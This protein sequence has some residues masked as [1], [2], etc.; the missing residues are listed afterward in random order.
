[1]THVITAPVALSLSLSANVGPGASVTLTQPLSAG[2]NEIRKA[3]W[4][5]LA[6]PAVTASR[7]IISEGKLAL[8]PNGVSPTVSPSI[9]NSLEL[10][11]I[12]VTTPANTNTVGAVSST[13]PPHGTL[14]I[15]D[16]K[17]IVHTGSVGNTAGT[18]NTY[19]G[20]TGL[21]Q[22]GRNG[23]VSGNWSGTGITTSQTLATAGNLTSIGV[24]TA[25]QVKGLTNPGDTGLWAGQTVTGTDVLVMYTYGGDANLDGKINVDDYG[26]ID[27]AVPIGINGWTNGDFNYD[28]K[29]NVD[30]YGIIDFNVGIQGPPFFAGAGAAGS[31]GTSAGT[32]AAVP[33][34]LGG[35]LA[36]VSL[37]LLCLRR[38]RSGRRI[39]GGR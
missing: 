17:L 35:V 11:Q 39:D 23:G 25:Q 6:T 34:P 3:G 24:A 12:N 33:E 38:R 9:V 18:N 2:G 32:L 30:D 16:N 28:G 27:F 8:S 37:T 15:G 29:I 22:Y 7:L 1:G 31:V 36:A 21:I 19:S 20:I 13:A 10:P 14:D 5:T 4:C 26:K